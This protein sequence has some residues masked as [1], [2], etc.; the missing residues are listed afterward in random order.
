M[1]FEPNLKENFQLCIRNSEDYDFPVYL[2]VEGPVA[3][4]VTLQKTEYDLKPHQLVCQVYTVHFPDKLD[5]YGPST[6]RIW[7]KQK[8]PSGSGTIQVLVSVHHKLNV[9]VPYPDKYVG[10]SL[11]TEDVNSNEPVQF[12]INAKNFGQD[13]IAKANARLDIYG[14][15]DYKNYVTTL[16]TSTKPIASMETADFNAVFDTVGV[17]PGYYK[18][19]AVLYFDGN[20]SNTS[21]IFKIGTLLV[22]VD[23]QTEK[24]VAGKIDPF[25]ITI[26]SRWN[27]EIDDVSAKAEFPGIDGHVL[28]RTV[29]LKPWEITTLNNYIDL[30]GVEPGDYDGRITVYF[31]NQTSM[32]DVMLHVMTEEEAELEKPQSVSDTTAGDKTG[33]MSK[34]NLTLTNILL[35]VVVLMVIA[36]LAYIMYR[37]RKNEK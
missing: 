22:R 5:F 33:Q 14:A 16:Y 31:A 4:Y 19:N 37:K 25:D 27:N 17:M 21:G 2:T 35:V 36:D 3:Q 8:A 28:T 1:T 7:V 24:A 23:N 32:K 11:E 6:T 29:N 15:D 26:E 9:F 13:D 18:A 20:S 12:T 10:I 34:G 30:T